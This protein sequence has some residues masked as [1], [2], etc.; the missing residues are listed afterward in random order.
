MNDKIEDRFNLFSL[1]QKNNPA[2][3]S[4][5]IV[6]QLLID[7]LGINVSDPLKLNKNS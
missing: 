3:N 6:V 5:R 2:L 1:K 4:E 7:I